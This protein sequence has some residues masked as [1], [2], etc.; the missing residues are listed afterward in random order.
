MGPGGGPT[1]VGGGGLRPAP[2]EARQPRDARGALH[3]RPSP[4]RESSQHG[5][6][7][8][9]AACVGRIPA[10]LRE[11]QGGLGDRSDASEGEGDVALAVTGRDAEEDGDL[12][13]SQ[14]LP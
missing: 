4:P 1:P 9:D 2:G 11:A 13:I 12:E 14:A 10:T 3:D 8:V 7:R 6:K 5:L